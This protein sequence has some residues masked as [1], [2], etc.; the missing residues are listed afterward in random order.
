MALVKISGKAV[1]FQPE[2]KVTSARISNNGLTS[3]RTQKILNYPWITL[4]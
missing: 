2:T 1:N 4:R 3:V